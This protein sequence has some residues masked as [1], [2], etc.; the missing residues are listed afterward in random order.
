MHSVTKNVWYKNQAFGIHSIQKV[1]ASLMQSIGKAGYFTNTSNRRTAKTRLTL[2]GIPR[3]ISKQKT[4]HIS[5]ADEV[6]IHCTFVNIVI[7][8]QIQMVILKNSLLPKYFGSNDH[9]RPN[10]SLLANIL[11]CKRAMVLYS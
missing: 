8:F 4:G 9:C 6:Y 3:E 11:K 2:A 7:V 1:T 5:M 10:F